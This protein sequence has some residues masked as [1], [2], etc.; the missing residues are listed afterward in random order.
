MNTAHVPG[1][2]IST[3]SYGR[4]RITIGDYALVIVP[5]DLDDRH[6][7]KPT[8]LFGAIETLG[9]ELSVLL[10]ANASKPVRRLGRD[11]FANDAERNAHM[12][13]YRSLKHRLTAHVRAQAAV[14]LDPFVSNTPHL[15][16]L[17]STKMK[18]SNNA[19][20]TMCPCSPGFILQRVVLYR[21]RP[22][23]LWI[24]NAVEPE[25]VIDHS[26]C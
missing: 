26:N 5:R 22:V 11:D 18:F 3:T 7:W 2:T 15:V 6:A 24:E 12:R 16:G 21:D 10:E 20:C 25:V 8:R 4:E 19:G 1:I 14:V 9:G 13:E 23:D 17:N